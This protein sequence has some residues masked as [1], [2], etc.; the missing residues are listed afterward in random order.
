MYAVTF[1]YGGG[2]S[3]TGVVVP[4]GGFEPYLSLFDS[5]GNF[6]A[7]TRSGVYC[8]PGANT[9]PGGAFGGCDDRPAEWRNSNLR[10]V[11]DRS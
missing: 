6:L 8:P 5:G 11:S 1:G 4:A 9:V 3:G 2:T 10:N 7:S